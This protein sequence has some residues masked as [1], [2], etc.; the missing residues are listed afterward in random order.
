[1][2]QSVAARYRKEL[3]RDRL[4]SLLFQARHGAANS[5]KTGKVLRQRFLDTEIRIQQH[6]VGAMLGERKVR[7]IALIVST[8]SFV[9]IHRY[10][11]LLALAFRS[12]GIS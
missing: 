1:M 5:I 8:I 7:C 3:F 9:I 11:P 12:Y 6:G 2:A 4:D 10:A